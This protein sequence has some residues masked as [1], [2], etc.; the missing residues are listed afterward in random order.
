MKEVSIK[1]VKELY[2]VS[3]DFI[4]DHRI[5]EALENLKKL[6]AKASSSDLLAQYD[7]LDNTYK[8]LLKYAVEGAEDPE[9]ERIYNKTR[10]SILELTDIVRQQLLTTHS[11]SFTFLFIINKI[12]T[13]KFNPNI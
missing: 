7:F 10:L 9:R 12:K 2:K 5:K 1:E 4:L 11:D 3:V 13:L 8:N 6:I